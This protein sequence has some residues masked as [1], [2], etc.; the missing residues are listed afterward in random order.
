MPV[1]QVAA[2]VFMKTNR[3][4]NNANCFTKSTLYFAAPLFSEAERTFN[5]RVVSLLIPFFDVY[6]PQEHGGLLVDMVDKGMNPNHASSVVFTLDIAALKK[7]EVVLIVLDGRSIDE[8]A[9]FE[10]GYAHAMGKVCYGLQTDPRRL[11]K[12]GINNPMID[13]ALQQVFSSLDDLLKWAKSFS[14][15]KMASRSFP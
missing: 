13:C 1:R 7:C 12:I 8:G 9:A 4:I 11:L 14:L 3:L 5:E 10:L 6:L 2:E 15:E